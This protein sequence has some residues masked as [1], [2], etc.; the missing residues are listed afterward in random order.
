M[1]NPLCPSL[2]PSLWS[3]D[4]EEELTAELV[5]EAGARPGGVNFPSLSISIS[6]IR[7][8]PWEGDCG[9]RRRWE[10]AAVC[11]GGRLLAGWRERS[12][13]AAVGGDGPP[14]RVPMPGSWLIGVL[15]T[16]PEL[17]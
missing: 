16:G 5:L 13:G 11:S 2:S 7:V 15:V 1:L 3:E 14:R 10:F 6:I 4:R 9:S 12:L 8:T 17:M